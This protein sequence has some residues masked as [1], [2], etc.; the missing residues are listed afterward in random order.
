MTAAARLDNRRRPGFAL[1]LGCCITLSLPA[2][3]RLI[4]LFLDPLVSGSC[5]LHLARFIFLLLGALLFDS[6]VPAQDSRAVDSVAACLA[7]HVHL[8]RPVADSVIHTHE[9][10]A[11]GPD[12][13]PIRPSRPWREMQGPKAFPL[14][15]RR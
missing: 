11:D 6:S 9:L 4:L 13:R 12:R 10:Q 3:A 14:A 7:E 2:L 8:R 5:S 15:P 1:L